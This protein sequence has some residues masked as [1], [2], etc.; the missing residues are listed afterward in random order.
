MTEQFPVSLF[1]PEIGTAMPVS[2]KR[3]KE[4]WQQVEESCRRVE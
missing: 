2:E 1:A 3:L 4:Q